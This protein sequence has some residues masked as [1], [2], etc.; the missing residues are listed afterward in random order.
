MG[1][2]S[3]GIIG[4]DSHLDLLADFS[5]V[6]VAQTPK[7]LLDKCNEDDLSLYPLDNVQELPV[8]EHWKSLLEGV[9]VLGKIGV[10]KTVFVDGIECEEFVPH[11]FT[12]E[13]TQVLAAVYM[14]FGAKIPDDMKEAFIEAG[15][16][17][18]W[19]KEDP[20]REQFVKA[21][22]EALKKYDGAPLYEVSEGLFQKMLEHLSG[23]E[24]KPKFEW[25]TLKELDAH[26]RK[27]AEELEQK[28]GTKH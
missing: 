15:E 22:I 10:N 13:D 17:D 20:E 4:G 7:E 19:A 5:E 2:W 21:Y 8:F 14:A 1:Y 28:Y 11:Q 16:I 27:V 12:V 18:G 25:L 23:E 24:V 3:C 26:S 9:G 6:L